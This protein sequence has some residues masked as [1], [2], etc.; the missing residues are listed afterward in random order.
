MLEA[1]LAEF[2]FLLR[3]TVFRKK[4]HFI[5]SSFLTQMLI[6]RNVKFLADVLQ[7]TDF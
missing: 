4:I 7:L 2:S 5:C 1:L 3:Y 6:N